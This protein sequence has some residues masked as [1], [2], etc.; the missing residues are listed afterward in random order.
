MTRVCVFVVLVHFMYTF[1]TVDGKA[2]FEPKKAPVAPTIKAAA[3]GKT[4]NAVAAAATDTMVRP[5]CLQDTSTAGKDT[6]LTLGCCAAPH[7]PR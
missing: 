4:L 7:T 3:Q 6:V 5:P 2:V 1:N